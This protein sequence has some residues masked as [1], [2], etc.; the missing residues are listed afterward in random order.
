MR[1][2]EKKIKKESRITLK[3]N[4]PEP[5]AKT[6]IFSNG[7]QGNSQ[8]IIIPEN[9][10]PSTSSIYLRSHA[11]PLSDYEDDLFNEPEDIDR[12]R[13]QHEQDLSNSGY[14]G[15]DWFDNTANFT[16]SQN[17]HHLTGFVP[18]HRDY[19]RFHSQR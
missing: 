3:R 14:Y 13:F 1:M 6:G 17:Q 5:K 7:I 4:T 16:Q 2:T 15:Q 10:S 12:A 8:Q 18:R 11:S 9:P 19:Y